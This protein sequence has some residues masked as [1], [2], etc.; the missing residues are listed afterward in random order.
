MAKTWSTEPSDALK[1][2]RGTALDSIDT[3]ASPGFGGDKKY[4]QQSLE[5]G[6]EQLSE[7]QEKLFADSRAAGGTKSVLLVLQAMDTA[8]KGG[9][10]RHVVG[11]V[12]PQGIKHHAFKKPTEEEL[13]HDFL[14]RVRNELP[15]VGMIGVFDRSHYEDVLVARVRSL[16][17][18][19]VLEQ[20]YDE[21]N[22]FESELVASGTTLIK[23]MLHISFDEQK[24]R[25]A[26]RLDRPDKHWKYNPGDIDERNLWADYQ[27]AYQVALD[28]TS[29]DQAPWFVV[30]ADKKWYARVAVQRLLITA[31][32]A[33][34][35][36]WPP[37]DF[38]VAVEKTRLA[39]S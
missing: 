15:G 31:L 16:V 22:A 1:F 12:D 4:G 13:A 18:T 23:V 26:E 17:S 11:A 21:I 10:V 6:R 25:L 9:I 24:A 8:G 37:A 39:A 3:D 33:Q 29:T 14:W 35:L 28:R 38:D 34:E 19:D 36:D 32:R 5:S 20:R 27:S 7:L 2:A 30:P